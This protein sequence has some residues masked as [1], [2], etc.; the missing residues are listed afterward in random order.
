MI[1]SESHIG[2]LDVPVSHVICT[3]NTE[4]HMGR[5]I[6]LYLKK[7]IPGLYDA[8]REQCKQKQLLVNTLWVYEHNTPKILCFPTKDKTWED[9]KLEWIET[10][11]RTL[12]DTYRDRGITSVAM[13]PLGCGN[14]GLKWEDVRPLI[15]AILGDCDLQVHLCLGVKL[16]NPKN[17][18]VEHINIWTKSSTSL[19]RRLSNLSKHGFLHE[20]HGWF[21]CLEGYW[22]W[23]ATGCK[24]EQFK[25]MNGF[26][27]KQIGSKMERVD[28]PDFQER[29]KEGMRLRLEQNEILRSELLNS[30]L[31]FEHYYVYG[32]DAVRDMKARHQWQLD[33]YVEYRNKMQEESE[34]SRKKPM[35]ILIA[36]SRTLKNYSLFK[37]ITDEY[38]SNFITPFDKDY[39]IELVTGL[40]L[41]GPDNMAIR[42]AREQGHGLI[43]RPALWDKYQKPAGMIRNG[44]MGKMVDAGLIFWDGESR[45]TKNMI[46]LLVK[47]NISHFVF[48][49]SKD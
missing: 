49:F 16:P 8:Y 41:D 43:G 45:G 34:S 5:G 17:D 21:E 2:I 38:I 3:V 26:E 7:C 24:H 42:Y 30:S 9:S 15:Y 10:N 27:A 1:V 36:G 44:V 4:G 20:D 29:F 13:P 18:G 48:I 39:D 28:L 46:D 31:P 14:G 6:A 22:Y 19:G 35:K 37:Q 12:R 11:L 23:L 40:A 32:N 25:Q 47:N 33:F